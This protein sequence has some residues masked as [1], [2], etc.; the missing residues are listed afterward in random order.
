ML[1]SIS[2]SPRINN[3]SDNDE[4]PETTLWR[5]TVERLLASGSSAVEAL[6][7]ANLILQAYQ[8]QRIAL[9]AS[10]PEVES[11]PR[12]ST[13]PTPEVEN[14]SRVSGVRRKTRSGNYKVK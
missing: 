14:P 1:W 3:L 8:R 4:T 11:P 7:G 5:E 13:V 6:D 9:R 2:C 10:I 12:V